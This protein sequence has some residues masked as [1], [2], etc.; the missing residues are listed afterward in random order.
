MDREA[1]VHTYDGLLLCYKKEHISVSSNET[2]EPG[3]YYTEWSKSETE[4][5]I[6]YINAY[7]WDLERCCWWTCFQG[8]NGD[9][10][11]ENT[12]VDSGEEGE[13]GTNG[14][15]SMESHYHM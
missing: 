6:L 4:R 14:E 13:S 2:D 9:T 3:A 15:S 8:S 10:D 7:T 5:Q 12:L 11:I 1:V